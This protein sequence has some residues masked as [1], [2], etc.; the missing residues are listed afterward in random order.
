MPLPDDERV[1]AV[2]PLSFKSC[3]GRGHPE[4]ASGRQQDAAEYFTH[5]LEL[6]RGLIGW[7]GG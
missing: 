7:G 4:F 6:V 1:T 3:V 5:L 2:R